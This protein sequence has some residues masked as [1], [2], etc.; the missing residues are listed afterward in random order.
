VDGSTYRVWMQTRW[1]APRYGS[2][3]RTPLPFNREMIRTYLRCD[4][5]AYKVVGTVV[6]LDDGPPVDSVIVGEKAASAGNWKD[7]EP[8]SADAGAGKG[9]CAILDARARRR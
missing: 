6:S 7:A 9:A 3:K 1:A 8:G 4:P 2:R 5:I